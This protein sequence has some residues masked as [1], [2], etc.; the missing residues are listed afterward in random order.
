MRAPL[1]PLALVV[2]VGC[3][4]WPSA[5]PDGGAT[6]DAGSLSVDA[7]G[8][9]SDAG[10]FTQ[11]AGADELDAGSATPDAGAVTPDAGGATDAGL[12]T[13]VV[14]VTT[15]GPVVAPAVDGGITGFLG[16]PYAAP[17]VGA[18][19]W[20]PP[21]PPEP[22]SAPRPAN[23]FGPACPQD[24]ADAGFPQSEDCLFVNVW[25]GRVEAS[26]HLPVMVFIH[27][28]GF[29]NGSGSRPTY[30][31]STLP[32]RNVVLVTLNYRLGNL[33]FLAHPLLTTESAHASSGNYGFLDQVAGL[34]WVHDNIAAFGGD[35]DNVTV[36]GESAGSISTCLHVFSPLSQ[37][38]FKRGIGES[39]SCL[40]TQTTLA[41]AEKM[42]ETFAGQV[43]CT[44]LDCLRGLTVAQITSVPAAPDTDFGLGVA[45][46]NVDGW[47]LP[48]AP[49]V[50]LTAGHVNASVEGFIG[51]VNRDEST[52]F[53]M[54]HTIDTEAA[55][56]AA[57][58]TALPHHVDDVLALYVPLS[59]D[60]PTYKS[61]Y[62]A[63]TTDMLFV[64]PTK[65]QLTGFAQNGLTTYLYRFVKETAA[66]NAT[67]LGVFHGSEL[68]FVFGTGPLVGPSKTLSG[69]MQGWW[70]GFATTGSPGAPWAPYSVAADQHLVIDDTS[71]MGTALR[72]TQCEAIAQWLTSP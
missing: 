26:A 31:G 68:P 50:A 48:E 45:T 19:R 44:T 46:P 35:P 61:V 70:S 43:Q 59:A 21:Q 64:C 71:A 42:G 58:T 60:Y 22:W 24:T 10:G 28:G 30:V 15:S 20:Q 25:S 65:Q 37:G 66:G 14:V 67:G 13:G 11:D 39:G 5:T 36:F 29:K 53:T 41:K 52:L 9:D 1:V 38:L 56:R 17:P 4:P 2:M 7:G 6:S 72:A 63:L 51:G 3:A 40:I 32:N 57:I 8:D 54:G 34:R 12:F 69:R 18:R 27:G 16:M 47:V 49:A 55:L 23:A 62:D 33:G